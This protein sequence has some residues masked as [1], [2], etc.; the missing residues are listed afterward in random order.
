MAFKWKK[1]FSLSTRE[2]TQIVC[3]ND[4]HAMLNAYILTISILTS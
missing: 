2:I 4:M 3:I 1:S